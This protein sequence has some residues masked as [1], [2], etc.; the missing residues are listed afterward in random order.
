MGPS[1][2]LPCHRHTL[3][4]RMVLGQGVWCHPGRSNLVSP[5]PWCCRAHELPS[6]HLKSGKATSWSGICRRKSGFWHRGFPVTIFLLR[7]QSPSQASWQ[8]QL[9]GLASRFLHTGES[10]RVA[11]EQLPGKGTC[12]NVHRLGASPGAQDIQCG[13]GLQCVKGARSNCADLVVVQGEQADVA[14]PC[15]AVIVD[16][17]DA[18]VPQHPAEGREQGHLQHR[19][20]PREKPT[21][22]VL[23]LCPPQCWAAE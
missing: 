9:K 7:S 17:A 18:V 22:A 21:L 15:E 12:S 1:E 3:A 13:E 6:S 2:R 23:R 5:H 8:L 10:T 4:A 14:Q 11:P 19:Q 16:A 20:A